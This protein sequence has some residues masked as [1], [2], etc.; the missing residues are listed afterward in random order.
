MFGMRTTIDIPD[1]LYKAV[2]KLD[3]TEVV[4]ES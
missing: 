1:V 3:F 4:K 2:R